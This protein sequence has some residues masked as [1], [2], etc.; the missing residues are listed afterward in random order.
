MLQPT[1]PAHDIGRDRTVGGNRDSRHPV[2]GLLQGGGP[3][4]PD[5]EGTRNGLAVDGD[6]DEPRPPVAADRFDRDSSQCFAL[7]APRPHET[8]DD[9][10]SGLITMPASSDRT[11]KTPAIAANTPA[12]ACSPAV[13]V[14]SPNEARA[15]RHSSPSATARTATTALRRMVIAA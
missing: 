2:D 13:A 3:D 6:N 15:M 8:A 5:R 7:N 12:P 1:R 14:V 9:N 11:A 10:P 4:P